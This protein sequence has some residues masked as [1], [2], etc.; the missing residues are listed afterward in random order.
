MIVFKPLPVR[1]PGRQTTSMDS[2]LVSSFAVRSA[3]SAR[4]EA[5]LKS[6]DPQNRIRKGSH[7]FLNAGEVENARCWQRSRD[8][9]MRPSDLDDDRIMTYCGINR[10]TDGA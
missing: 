5:M 4:K 2:I 9:L 10:E 3:F 7:V 6:S 1:F 8:I